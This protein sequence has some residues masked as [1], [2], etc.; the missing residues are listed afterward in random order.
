MNA[1][2]ALAALLCIASRAAQSSA[3]G[4]L[5]EVAGEPWPVREGY[6]MHTKTLTY[7]LLS[8]L[9]LDWIAFAADGKLASGDG[10]RQLE[11]AGRVGTIELGFS[12]DGKLIG[13][14]GYETE[15]G[16]EPASGWTLAKADADTIAGRFQYGGVD[17][18]FE[19][20]IRH[21]E[22]EPQRALTK[23]SAPFKALVAFY[24]TRRAGD[25]DAFF[26]AMSTPEEFAA[27]DD[28]LRENI[29]QS[30][31]KAEGPAHG[32]EFQRGTMAGNVAY[33]TCSEPGGKPFTMRMF[34]VDRRWIVND[35]VAD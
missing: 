5:T 11:I 24:E 15:A 20:P 27:I 3:S 12:P 33:V 32:I 22:L 29:R 30:L 7:V 2:I 25:P 31:A 9:P 18:E 4:T 17:V 13:G 8:H 16:R 14:S 34:R 35:E 21:S 6:A 10:T 23:D 28:T 19:L 1:R 26:A